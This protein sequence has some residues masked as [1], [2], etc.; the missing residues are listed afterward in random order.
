MRAQ[1]VEHADAALAVAKDDEVLAEQAHPHRRAIGFG[2]FL[3]QAG[4]DPVAAHDL[5]HRRRSFDAAQQVVFLG[6]HAIAP[7]ALILLCV[8]ARFILDI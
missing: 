1:F 2:D 6:C 4:R 5:P 8:T 3:G 7:Y